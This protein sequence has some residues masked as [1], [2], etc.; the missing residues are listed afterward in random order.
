MYEVA[1]PKEPR[2]CHLCGEEYA[3]RTYNQ[4]YCDKCRDEAR[5]KRNLANALKYYEEHREEVL[6]KNRIRKRE[7]YVPRPEHDYR[8]CAIC[9][10]PF[11]PYTL[12]TSLYCSDM[13]RRIAENEHQRQ[14]RAR[15]RAS[16]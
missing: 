8:D 5:R 15:R 9:G 6:E 10:A 12:T 1:R 14:R 11:V 7:Q 16:A 13:C 4:K 3:P 2:V